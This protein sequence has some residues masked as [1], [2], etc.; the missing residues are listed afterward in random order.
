[1]EL[2]NQ[3][4]HWD[5]RFVT[6]SADN[7]D[8]ILKN[9]T[10]MAGLIDC[11]QIHYGGGV[12]L[13][14]RPSFFAR[15]FRRVKEMLR[16]SIWIMRRPGATL[17]HGRHFSD[18]PYTG[19]YLL[20]RMMGGKSV[21]LARSRLIDQGMHEIFRRRFNAIN[22]TPNLL[23]RLLGRSADALVHYHD[24]QA[25]YI[26]S[27][28]KSGSISNLPRLKLGAPNDLPT[29]RALIARESKAEKEQ[30]IPNNCSTLEIYTF[31]ATK[32]FSS[33]E[34]RTP[35]SVE[36]TTWTILKLLSET[37]PEAVILLR[38][39]PLAINEFY[40]HTILERLNNPRIIVTLV[41]PEILIRLS[42][43]T[44]VNA[45]TNILFTSPEGRFIDCTDYR[46]S[47]LDARN[48]EGFAAGYGA[49]YLNP[50]A[51]DFAPRFIDALDEDFGADDP[52]I[53]SARD[54]LRENNPLQLEALFKL[55][56][57]D[58]TGGVPA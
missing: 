14:G 39:H 46:Q 23:D 28:G 2:K 17:F 56:N 20:N 30:L 27:L 5:I 7:Y 6:F 25:L 40:L 54:L 34:L 4:P 12:P 45:P 51:S 9:Q 37:K 3:R 11:G 42:R 50:T 57:T 47:D 48:G 8:F 26:K 55:L 16:I 53:D 33:T 13:E 38:P 44:I 19:W 49:L 10:L 43:R 32:A 21:I 24:Q 31:F 1:M 36:N 52:E 35:E 22:E 41:H 29:W 15:A 58:Q 18:G